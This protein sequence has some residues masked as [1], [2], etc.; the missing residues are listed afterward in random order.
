MEIQ[1]K[2]LVFCL[3]ILLPSLCRC[4]CVWEKRKRKIYNC[5]IVHLMLLLFC[6]RRNGKVVTLLKTSSLART[7]PKHRFVKVLCKFRTCCKSLWIM[8]HCLSPD[9][10]DSSDWPSKL[11]FLDYFDK[12]TVPSTQHRK[13]SKKNWRC[14]LLLAHFCAMHF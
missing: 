7:N 14:H 2:I 12:N 11:L 5:T 3:S 6:E 8:C 4:V 9:R 13:E 10:Q 1:L